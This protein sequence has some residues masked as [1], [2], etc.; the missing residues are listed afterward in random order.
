[1]LPV[2][3]LIRTTLCPKPQLTIADATQLLTLYRNVINQPIHPTLLL[4]LLASSVMKKVTY[5]LNAQQT[6]KASTFTEG[7][8][9]S[10]AVS[11]ISL[12]IVRHLRKGVKQPRI[13]IGR[14]KR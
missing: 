13:E 14:G 3:Y 8:V 7:S 11:D 2:S 6:T 4:T 10:A 5:P 12:K 9:M 1:M